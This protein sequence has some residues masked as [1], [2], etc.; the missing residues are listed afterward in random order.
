MSLGYL[1]YVWQTTGF[2]L[3]SRILNN[4]GYQTGT[5]LT[6]YGAMMLHAVF[7]RKDKYCGLTSYGELKKKKKGA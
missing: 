7:R 6:K 2:I 4:M 1:K 5:K 3:V